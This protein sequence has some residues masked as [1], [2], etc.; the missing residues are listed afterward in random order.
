MSWKMKNK[1]F[2]YLDFPEGIQEPILSNVQTLLGKH[3]I[4]G[5]WFPSRNWGDA[6]SPR[7]IQLLSGKKPILNNKYTFNPHS[8]PVYTAIGS[9]LGGARM[10]RMPAKNF[11]VWGSGFISEFRKLNGTPRKICAVRGP[12]TR[13][14]LLKQGIQCPEIYG[15]PALL[16]PTF[17]KPNIIRTKKLGVIPHYLEKNHPLLN[18]FR[19]DPDILLIDI[20]GDINVVVD[21]IC[22]CQYI[23]S[24]SLHGIIAADAYGIPSTWIKI[25]DIDIGYGFKYQDYFESV[26]REDT[27]PFIIDASV[28]IDSLFNLFYNHRIELDFN[29]LLDACP[30]INEGE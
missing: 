1:L 22:S 30:F 29:L 9:I 10:N 17:Y 2:P 19:N 24:S 11:I 3:S 7:L 26:G 28:D 16:Y 8:E 6:L 21:Q 25:S 13:N 23:A 15:D 20:E 4:R 18:Q 12:L 27:K 14:M 5:Y